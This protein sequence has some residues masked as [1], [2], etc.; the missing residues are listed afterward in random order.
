MNK[1]KFGTGGPPL[2]SKSRKTIDG[3]M[4][5]HELGLDNMEVEFVHGVKMTEVEA[6]KVAK[7]A[8][9]LEVDLTVHGP[10]YINLASL[11]K[12]IWYASIN[13]IIQSLKIGEILEA[14][15]VTFHSGFFQAQDSALVYKKV[16][17]AIREIIRKFDFH[18]KK[19]RLSP[20]LTGK[21]TQFGDLDDLIKLAEEFKQI[22]LRFCI[23]FAHKF[24]RS[25]GVFNG[26][27]KTCEILNSIKK[28]LGEK[29][30]KE[31]HIHLSNIDYSKK[32]ER[33]HLT[34][35]P[36]ACD[37]INII[38]NIPEEKIKS[39][40]DTLPEK[41]LKPGEFRWMETIEVLKEY[42][43]TGWVVC[44]SPVLELDAL[45]MKDYYSRC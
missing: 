32:G 6:S 30:L 41:K 7:L 9:K 34:Y 15:S 4:R 21:P 8:S 39:I 1:L 35:L 42:K 3:I 11:E 23:D 19:I 38:K 18:N 29:F 36:D 12:P 26:Y 31:M 37:Y 17:D 33:N 43:V 5:I 22:D 45:V 28:M 25:N 20:E 2:T 13:R 44:E 14:E 10:Y 16:S 40:L 27:E 24:A